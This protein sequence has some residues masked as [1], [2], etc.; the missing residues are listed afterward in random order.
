MRIFVHYSKIFMIIFVSFYLTACISRLARPELLGQLFDTEN[1]PIANA[2]VGEVYSDI[3]GQ[4]ILPEQRYHAFF[5]KEIVYMEAPPV[6]VNEKVE[7]RG[8]QPCWIRLVNLRG[9]GARKGSKVDLGKIVLGA[10][11]QE[12]TIQNIDCESINAK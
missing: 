12:K 6:F 8:F 9:G 4:F 7:K 1:R 11:H 3:N 5:F 2:K 10:S